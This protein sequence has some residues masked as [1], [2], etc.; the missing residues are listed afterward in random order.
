MNTDSY[1]IGLGN[2]DTQIR[3]SAE[4]DNISFGS[5][6]VI[7]LPIDDSFSDH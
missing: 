7:R 3:K 2:L 4:L 1:K 5:A 6:K